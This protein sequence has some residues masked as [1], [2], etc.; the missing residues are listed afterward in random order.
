MIRVYTFL[1]DKVNGYTGP[2]IQ[3]YSC[4]YLTENVRVACITWESKGNTASNPPTLWSITF[5]NFHV[6]VCTDP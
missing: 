4:F 6:R 1:T 2:V 5:W 3:L